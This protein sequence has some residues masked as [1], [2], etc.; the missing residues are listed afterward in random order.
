MTQLSCM[1]CGRK[2][3]IMGKCTY[4]KGRCP[5]CRHI[6]FIPK[7]DGIDETL[8]KTA[9]AK[10]DW[11][12]LSDEQIL[13]KMVSRARIEGDIKDLEE[14]KSSWKPEVIA[15]RTFMPS[16]D[17]LTLF[18]LSFALIALCL[19][20]GKLR[21][22][23]WSVFSSHNMIAVL[24]ASLMA[25]FMFLSFINTFFQREKF[26]FEKHLMLWFA[27]LVSAGTGIYSGYIIWEES[28]GWLLIFP[29]WNIANGVILLLFWQLGFLD[30]EC[31][32]ENEYNHFQVLVSAASV[33][34]ILGLCDYIFK[35]HWVISYSICVC[36]TIT[37]NDA[38]HSVLGI[39]RNKPADKLNGQIT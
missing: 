18:T 5:S 4:G 29:I 11:S 39:N 10:R 20:N 38:I 30:T 24:F 14:G 23:L 3:Q 13:Q 21:E 33:G 28:K 36:Y 25:G 31:I 9:N 34:I 26:D 17:D 32:V 16:Y 12:N 2:L 8:Q 6:I 27:V 19:M 37:I 1:Y 15:M 35:M 7:E 22:S